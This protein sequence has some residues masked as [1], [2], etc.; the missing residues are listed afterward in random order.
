MAA[1]RAELERREPPPEVAVV[2]VPLLFEAGI[3]G[4]FDAT[5]AVVADEALRAERA[6]A[7]DHEGVEGREARQLTQEEKAARADHVIRNDG[8]AG[9][10]RGG[11]GGGARPSF[12]SEGRA[13]EAAG[14]WPARLRGRRTRARGRRRR[15]GRRRTRRDPARRMLGTASSAAA[16]V[17]KPTVDDAIKEITLPLR[18]ED[19]IRQQARDKNLDPALIAAVIY[20]ES[21]FRDQ[22]SQAGRQ[23]PDADPARARRSSSRTAAGGTEFEQR[24]LAN[25]QINI[26]YGCWYLRYLL[27]RYDGNEV[28]AVAA[29]NAGHARVDSWGGSDAAR[30]T[31]SASPRPRTTRATCST[32]AASTRSKYRVGAGL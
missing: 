10:A 23:G 28:A 15:R 5:V 8:I 17:L 9:R 1:W 14:R 18:H 12:A 29:Y 11:G 2:E 13:D 20:R 24:D 32:S 27:D 3:E 22:T 31:T 6:A 30:W 19:V 7:R 16:I 4:V 21:K 25:P 26:S